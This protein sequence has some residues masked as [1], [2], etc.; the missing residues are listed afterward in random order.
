MTLNAQQ[1]LIL[2]RQEIM[3][4]FD[5]PHEEHYKWLMDLYNKYDKSDIFYVCGDM[6]KDYAEYYAMF[7]E[8]GNTSGL[9]NL[10]KK[11]III[12]KTLMGGMVHV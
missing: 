11:L 4:M 7:M 8:D 1:R 10:R 2:I 5:M 3:G 6:L 12:A 9:D